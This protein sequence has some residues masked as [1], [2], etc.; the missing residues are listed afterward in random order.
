MLILDTQTYRDCFISSRYVVCTNQYKSWTPGSSMD[1]ASHRRS[2]G[3]V[4]DSRLANKVWVAVYV[5]SLL[6]KR[7]LI[8]LLSTYQNTVIVS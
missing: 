3:C 5:P 2:E 4:F 6:I 7:S 8:S 1:R